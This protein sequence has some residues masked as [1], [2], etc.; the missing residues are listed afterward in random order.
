[1]VTVDYVYRGLQHYLV[2]DFN[3][4]LLQLRLVGSV[5][6]LQFGLQICDLPAYLV[7]LRA[8]RAERAIFYHLLELL[9]LLI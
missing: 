5:Y 2:V 1:M 8:I 3:G 6:L 4:Q 7:L 9:S